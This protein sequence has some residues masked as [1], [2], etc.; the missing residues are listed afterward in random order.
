MKSNYAFV[1]TMKNF[2]KPGYRIKLIS[3]QDPAGLPSGSLGTVDYVD[4]AGQ[5][6]MKWDC[7]SSLA[8][9][10]NVDDFRL[11]PDSC[12]TKYVIKG[13]LENKDV[14]YKKTLKEHLWGTEWDVANFSETITESTLFDYSE[15]AEEVCTQ[16]GFADFKVYPVCPMCHE[17]YSGH[18]AIS[19]HDNKTKICDKC[20][21]I[22]ALTE[23]VEYQ[24]KATNQ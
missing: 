23:F 6:Q 20:G 17:D 13:H 5:I 22:E 21:L 24:K 4:D 19:R 15:T 10:Q 11:I 12:G 2:Y 18:P 3:M 7:G 16:I 8:L 1:N 14:Y 9:I